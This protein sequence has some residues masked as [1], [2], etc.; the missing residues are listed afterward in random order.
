MAKDSTSRLLLRITL[1]HID[2]PIWRR[3]AVAD[4]I[5]L[6]QMHSVIQEA[7]GWE[8]WHP[9][10]TANDSGGRITTKVFRATSHRPVDERKV[11]LAEALRQ[12]RKFSYWYDFGDDWWHDIV[13]EGHEA[14]MANAARVALLAGERAAL[15]KIAAGL[16][17]MPSFSRHSPILIIPS[18]RRWS[19]G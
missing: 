4:D 9:T 1:R 10:S 12:R 16:M 8:D 18:M 6:A 11:T 17:V 5:T 3:V 14:A 19:I 13:V 2:P 15:R 7:F